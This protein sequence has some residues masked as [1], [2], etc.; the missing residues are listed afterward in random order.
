MQAIEM[1]S[2]PSLPT[3]RMKAGRG[4]CAQTCG[5]DPLPMEQHRECVLHPPVVL[6]AFDKII[7]DDDE[8]NLCPV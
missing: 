4:L 5:P 6:D 3:D 8:R 7:S 2:R 1:V